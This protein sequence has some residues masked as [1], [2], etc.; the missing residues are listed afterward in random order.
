M[1]KIPDKRGILL[2]GVRVTVI[3]LTLIPVLC[4]ATYFER[5]FC[6]FILS[7]PLLFPEVNVYETEFGGIANQFDRAVEAEFV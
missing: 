2:I 3:V 4:I 6:G 5:R 1:G 7:K